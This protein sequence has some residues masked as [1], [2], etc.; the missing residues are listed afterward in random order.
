MNAELENQSQELF[1]MQNEIFKSGKTIIDLLHERTKL[2]EQIT[3]CRAELAKLKAQRTQDSKKILQVTQEMIKLV[4]RCNEINKQVIQ[5]MVSYSIDSSAM[6]FN[7]QF[8][9]L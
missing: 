2:K 8:H 6:L 5:W 9:F 7:F 3:I 1:K 4:N